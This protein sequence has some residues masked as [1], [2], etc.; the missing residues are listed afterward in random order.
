MPARQVP[1]AAPQLERIMQ[2]LAPRYPLLWC[3]GAVVNGWSINNNGSSSNMNNNH[4]NNNENKHG[5]WKEQ[6]ERRFE[7]KLTTTRLLL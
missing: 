1:H 7:M 4:N 3:C 2:P 6:C 5:T